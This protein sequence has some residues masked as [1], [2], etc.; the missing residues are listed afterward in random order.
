MAASDNPGRKIIMLRRTFLA[1]PVTLLAAC[2]RADKID[3]KEGRELDIERLRKEIPAIAARAEPGVLGV[4]IGAPKGGDLYAFNGAR[5]FPMQSVF[6]APLGAAVLDQADGGLLSLAETITI[7]DVDLSPTWSPVADAWP[8]VSRYTVEDLL[9]RAVNDSDNTAADLLLK[10]IGGPGALTAWLKAKGVQGMRVDRYEREL[11]P[12]SVGLASFRADWKGEA[13]YRAAMASVPE[14]RQREAADAY[15]I[16]PRDTSTPAAMMDFLDALVAGSLVSRAASARLLALM[17]LPGR[18]TNR[19]VAAA[20][21][22]AKLAHK[23]GTSWTVAGRSLATNDAGIYTLADGRQ[24]TVVAFLTGSTLEADARERIIA[25]VGRAA[26][27]A[28]R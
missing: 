17:S 13:A 8:Q 19:L 26:I 28:M 11:G 15:L 6:K 5:P 1:A 14:A 21:P 10:R 18:I 24:L 4:A 2:N 12:E 25:D 23:P 22:G 3:L 27:G 7:R 9:K 20:P 16:D